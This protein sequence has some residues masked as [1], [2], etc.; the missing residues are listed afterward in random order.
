MVL[1][2]VCKAGRVKTIQRRLLQY[3]AVS[4]LVEKIRAGDFDNFLDLVGMLP[5]E[6]D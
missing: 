6:V 3:F 5:P 2:H 4:W 1:V